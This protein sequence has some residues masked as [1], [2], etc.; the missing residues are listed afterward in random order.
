MEEEE[1]EGE[2]EHHQQQQ[3]KQEQGEVVFSTSPNPKLEDHPL[4]A[5]HECFSNI[6]AVILHI[7]RPF[8]IQI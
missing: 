7:W 1:E 6:F 3:Q 2:E 8:S 5:L 4:L